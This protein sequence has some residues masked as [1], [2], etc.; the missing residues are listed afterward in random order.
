M[1]TQIF[2][3]FVFLTFVSCTNKKYELREAIN[4]N[5]S[6]DIAESSTINLSDN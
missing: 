6:W 5:G 3:F 1:K 2:L 4:L